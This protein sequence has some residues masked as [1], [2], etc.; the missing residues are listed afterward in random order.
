MKA[1]KNLPGL[2]AIGRRIRLKSQDV[3]G[4]VIN[5]R[6]LYYAGPDKGKPSGLGRMCGDDGLTYWID[7]GNWEFAPPKAV[8]S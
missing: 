6:C 4:I 5:N 3:Y 7:G 1:S 8:T 2:P